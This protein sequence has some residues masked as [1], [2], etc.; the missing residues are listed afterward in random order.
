MNKE[1]NNLTIDNLMRT[2][3]I[4]QFDEY[5][6]RKI[7]QG[8]RN[9]LDIS[10]YAKKEFNW[11]QMEQIRLG[12]LYDLDVSVYAKKEFPSDKMFKI[13]EKLLRER[14]KLENE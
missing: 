1:Y 10:W 14:E 4:N 2:D 7:T 6:I 13:R 11:L 9:Q 8:I 3:W 5:Q 12:L